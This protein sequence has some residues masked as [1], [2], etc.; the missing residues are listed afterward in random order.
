MEGTVKDENRRQVSDYSILYMLRREQKIT[1]PKG[2]NF[3]NGLFTGK[4]FVTVD[5]KKTR[6]RK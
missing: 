2:Q 1:P 6:K 4:Q 5:N 3:Y